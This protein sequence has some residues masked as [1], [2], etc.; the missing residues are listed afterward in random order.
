V[1]G[2]RPLITFTGPGPVIKSNLQISQV[3]VRGAVT[4][5]ARSRTLVI[6]VIIIAGGQKV[7]MAIS[8]LYQKKAGAEKKTSQSL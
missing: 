2:C 8:Q 7:N 6:I 3:K 5:R 4:T 1:A